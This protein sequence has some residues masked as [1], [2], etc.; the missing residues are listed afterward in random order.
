LEIVKRSGSSLADKEQDSRA[1]RAGLCLAQALNEVLQSGSQ[2]T[3][4][5]GI[6]TGVEFCRGNALARQKQFLSG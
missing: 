6:A 2:I 5:E 4:L 1:Q 3:K